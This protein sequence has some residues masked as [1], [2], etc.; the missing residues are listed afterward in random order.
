MT[1]VTKK[2]VKK[3]QTEEDKIFGNEPTIEVTKEFDYESADTKY[4]VTS[5][6]EGTTPVYVNGTVIETFIG[7][8]NRAARIALKEGAKS[9][10]CK[11]QNGKDMY[12]IEVV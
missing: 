3:V 6:E 4:R 9:V 12:K 11:D 1:R 7:S 8:T 5:L 2:T 10:V